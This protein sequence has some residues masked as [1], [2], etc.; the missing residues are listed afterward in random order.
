MTMIVSNLVHYI[1]HITAIGLGLLLS[2][3]ATGHVVLNKRDSRSAIAWVGFV[4]LVPLFGAVMYFIFGVNRIRHKAALLRRNLERYRVQAAQPECLP[5]ELQRHLPDHGGYL[6][7]LARVV[8]GVVERP[9]LPG[10]RI[11][12]LV[13][14]DEAYPAMLEAI[15][16]ARQTVSFVTYIFDRDEVGMVFAH[17][18]GEAARRGVEV[19]VLIDAT[20]ARYS[21]PTIL[22]TLQR[23]GVKHARFLPPL[24]LWH[25]M[26]INMR[27]HRKILVVDGRVGFTGGMNIRVGHC[28]QRQ[29]KKPVQDIHFRVKGPVVTQLQEVFTDDWLFTTGESLRG[30]LWFPQTESVGQVLARG[31]TDG[32]DENF[33][34]L[35]WTLLGALSIARHSVRIMT[36]YFLPDSAVVSALNLAAMRGVQVDIILPAQINLPF[37]LWASRAMWWQVLQHGCRIWLTP[38]PFD[39]S[40][41]MLVDGCWVL[42]GSA[43]WDARSLRLNFEFNVECYDVELA[44]RLDQWV[45]TKR[46]SARPVTLEEVDGRSLPARLR[47]GI[48]RLLTPY[49]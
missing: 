25:L 40:K 46:K 28:L 31:V 45:E 11:D 20:G 2:V 49:L 13:N 47:D 21:W 8:G 17:A 3:L 18:L 7:M 19:R 37:V 30:D 5:E 24:A 27:T 22:H 14:G 1:W 29:P 36:P 12:P 38:P 42:L 48:A 33:E 9:L 15:Q 32:P 6:K 10:N 39:H 26:S 23:E 41:L 44:K 34:K 43:N 35:R 4:W 16:H